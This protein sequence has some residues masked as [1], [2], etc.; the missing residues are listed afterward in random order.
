MRAMRMH[1]QLALFPLLRSSPLMRAS[2]P[3]SQAQSQMALPHFPVCE[4]PSTVSRPNRRPVMSTRAV[5]SGRQGQ[6]AGE[7]HARCLLLRLTVIRLS[8]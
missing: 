4:K 3:Q 6:M 8:G 5:I 2:F 7:E 1:P